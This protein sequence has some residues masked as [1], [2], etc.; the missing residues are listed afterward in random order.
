MR[1]AGY[2]IRTFSSQSVRRRIWEGQ[3]RELGGRQAATET[4]ECS[5]LG[6]VKKLPR[7]F[8][9]ASLPRAPGLGPASWPLAAS[10]KAR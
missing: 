2:T 6:K 8:P 5:F 10:T 9:R 1:T 3:S 7:S 4:S